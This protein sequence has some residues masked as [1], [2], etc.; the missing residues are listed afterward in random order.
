MS[1]FFTFDKEK[2]TFLIFYLCSLTFLMLIDE[3]FTSFPFQ[4][5]SYSI[6]LLSNG[7]NDNIYIIPLMADLDSNT[8][9]TF[10]YEQAI[11]GPLIDQANQEIN[12]MF[13]NV[14]FSASWVAVFTWRN[15][16]LSKLGVSQ[17]EFMG[18]LQYITIQIHFLDF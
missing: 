12:R 15:V 18:S 8:R 14:Y 17:F 13:P 2:Q 11:S 1:S 5:N 16:M 7:N 6:A 3:Y 10:A 9:G 4:A